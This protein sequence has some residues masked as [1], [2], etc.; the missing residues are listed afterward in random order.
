MKI[1]VTGGSGFIGT[2][3]VSILLKQGNE[4][5][6][7]DKNKPL[8]GGATFVQRDITEPICDVFEEHMPDAV[9][10]LAAQTML[11]YSV[12]NPIEDAKT[13]ILGTINVL[14]A[15]K[16]NGVKRLIYTSTGG[17]RYGVYPNMPASEKD[18]PLPSSPYGISKHSAEHYVDLYSEDLDATILCFGNVYGP[19]DNPE[20]KR[21]IAVFID[22]ILKDE[23]PTIFGDGKQTRDFVYVK[24]LATFIA[25]IVD[26]KG[27]HILYN[28]SSGVQ[29]SVLEIVDLIK[30]YT[31]YEGEI[32]FT[33]GI[34]GEVRDI[35]LDISLARKELNWNPKTSIEQGIKETVEWF[36]DQQ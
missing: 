10:H 3:V 28:V 11:R 1:L 30:K 36:K 32:L 29:S 4:V 24:D 6:V 16:K 21:L 8:V 17:A 20:T 12:D 25:S 35:T 34:K 5:I 26:K 33:D 14:G 18:L 15:C 27:E 19:G 22:K 7:L 9:I 31:A 23:Q 2:H 13:N